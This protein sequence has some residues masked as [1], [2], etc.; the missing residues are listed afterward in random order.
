MAHLAIILAIVA[1]I[2]QR[3]VMT[4]DYFGAPY[5]S[6]SVSPAQAAPH[7]T[8]AQVSVRI[9]DAVAAAGIKTQSYI[10][11]SLTVANRGDQLYTPDESTF[12]HDCLNN[13]IAI[14]Y[15]AVTEYVMALDQPSMQ[16]V[17][18][19]WLRRITSV[20]HFDAVFEDD[21]DLPSEYLHFRSLPCRYDDNA[22]IQSLDALN[23]HSPVPL[24]ISGLDAAYRPKASP[25]IRLASSN[26]T[27]GFN[28]EHCYS[29]DAAHP[30]TT[31]TIWQA[32]ENS[33]L[34]VTATGKLF[35][36]MARDQTA[37]ESAIDARTYLYA[38]FLLSYD[39]ATSIIW[40][41]FQTPSHFRVEPES[42]LVALSPVVR[43]PSDISG[44]QT[45]GGTYARQYARCYIAGAYVGACVAVVNP[46]DAARPFPFRDYRHTLVLRGGGVLDGGTIAAD[47]PA[48]PNALAPR[49]AVIAFR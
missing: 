17:F 42:Q 30:K 3:H 24:I 20:A 27:L 1:S 41:E 33:E 38:S 25:I 11:P 31:G 37:A 32:T 18:E 26:K 34:Q 7:L 21:D 16:A 2:S 36:C 14:P 29:N 6:T 45:P 39:P 44:L 40:E 48:P 43:A 5:G 9:A 28:F 22:W 10:D 8:W 19:R 49:A 35:T 12:A 46:T 13:R 4:G 23:Q 47:G 15:D